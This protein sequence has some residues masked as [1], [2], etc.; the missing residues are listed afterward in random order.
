MIGKTTQILEIEHGLNIRPQEGIYD[1]LRRQWAFKFSTLSLAEDS[2]GK[3]QPADEE[4][5]A[6]KGG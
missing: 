6:P 3:Q 4:L 2:K 5:A 1:R